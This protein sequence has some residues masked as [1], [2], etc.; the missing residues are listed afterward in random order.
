MRRFV[1]GLLAVLIT[2]GAAVAVIGLLM[3]AVL[4][5]QRYVITGGSMT[6]TISRGSLA[7]DE[8]VPSSTLKVGDIITFVPPRMHGPVTHRIISIK[9][10]QR[11]NSLFRTK[12]DAN[13]A[14]DPWQFALTNRTQARFVFA[15][16]YVGYVLAVL[17][18]RLARVVLLGIPAALIFFSI[19]VSMWRE[20]GKEKAKAAAESAALVTPAVADPSAPSASGSAKPAGAQAL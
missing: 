14:A 2:A 9:T 16:P 5:L 7:Y 3:P 8:Y 6:G 12:G 17:S 11:G 15:I 1:R 10:D 13:K 20:A 4:H 18:L 19:V